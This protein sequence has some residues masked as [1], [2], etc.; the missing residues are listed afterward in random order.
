M[1]EDWKRVHLEGIQAEVGKV[2]DRIRSCHALLCGKVTGIVAY[3]LHRCLDT[4]LEPS[5]DGWKQSDRWS[6][7]FWHIVGVAVA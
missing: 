7:P 4:V 2:V 1:T 3:P 5:G 6:V